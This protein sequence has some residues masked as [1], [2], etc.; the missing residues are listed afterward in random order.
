[1][2]K[3][4]YSLW[5]PILLILLRGL[6]CRFLAILAS[7]CLL[8]L[9][10]VAFSFRFPGRRCFCFIIRCWCFLSVAS[11][12]GGRGIG[13]ILHWLCILSILTLLLAFLAGCASPG[14]LGV[15]TCL[16]LMWCCCLMRMFRGRLMFIC[17]WLMWCC[18]IVCIFRGRV[19]ASVLSCFFAGLTTFLAGWFQSFRVCIL[20]FTFAS[21]WPL[22]TASL[23]LRLCCCPFGFCVLLWTVLAC[24]WLCCFCCFPPSSLLS[25]PA[26]GSEAEP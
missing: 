20:T 13:F 1:M 22:A 7:S 25:S 9:R 11:S 19:Y 17:F 4:G 6:A 24:R 12:W 8:G 23:W 14:G 26:A 15:R 10:S 5:N 3:T 18:C 2:S 16:W 21:L